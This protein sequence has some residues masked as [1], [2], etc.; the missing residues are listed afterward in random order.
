MD[1]SE[2]GSHS[3]YLVFVEENDTREKLTLN[4]LHLVSK[5]ERVNFVNEKNSSCRDLTSKEV[6]VGAIVNN[7][8]INEEFIPIFRCPW[9][10]FLLLDSC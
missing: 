9:R 7:T 4:Q 2:G 10:V 8:I 3:N 1:S 5:E 6:S